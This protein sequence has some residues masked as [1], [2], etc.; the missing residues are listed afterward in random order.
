MSGNWCA[1]FWPGEKMSEVADQELEL[2]SCV[3][4]DGPLDGIHQTSCQMC[5]GKFHRPWTEANDI[6]HCGRI[7]SHEDA[8]AVVFLCNDCYEGQR[9]QGG[10]PGYCGS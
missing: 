6:P 4:C 5:G 10:G 2:E 1:G 7:A 8:L 3:I 9:P